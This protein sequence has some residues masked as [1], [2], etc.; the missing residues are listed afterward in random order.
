[1]ISKSL[2]CYLDILTS[3]KESEPILDTFWLAVL[4][5]SEQKIYV[6]HRIRQVQQ[7]P[8]SLDLTFYDFP[9]FL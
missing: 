1:M 9:L 5:L 4:N 8:F 6:K 3:L 2:D 7:D